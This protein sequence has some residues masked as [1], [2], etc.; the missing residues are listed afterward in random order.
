MEEG[1]NPRPMPASVATKGLMALASCPRGHP[2]SS[3]ERVIGTVKIFFVP[4][5]FLPPPPEIVKIITSL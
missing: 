5:P 4:S 2:P 3:G 1:K